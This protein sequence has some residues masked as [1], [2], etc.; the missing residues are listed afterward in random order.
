MIAS[1]HPPLQS[2]LHPR[3]IRSSRG[4]SLRSLAMAVLTWVLPAA[5]VQF[6]PIHAQQVSIE[7]ALGMTF[8]SSG[9]AVGFGGPAEQYHEPAFQIQQ[10]DFTQEP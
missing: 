5:M 9:D 1:R 8:F 2:K 4:G 6:Q 3:N 10:A 7:D